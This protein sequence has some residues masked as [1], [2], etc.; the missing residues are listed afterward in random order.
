MTTTTMMMTMMMTG[1]IGDSGNR[2]EMNQNGKTGKVS[3][4]TKGGLEL[5]IITLIPHELYEV[6]QKVFSNVS[7]YMAV[8]QGWRPGYSVSIRYEYL[9]SCGLRRTNNLSGDIEGKELLP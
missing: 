8:F 7:T 3:F 4:L 5:F 2:P 1:I 6:A 9:L